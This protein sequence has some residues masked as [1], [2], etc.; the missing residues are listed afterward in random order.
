MNTSN[1]SKH[2]A[3]KLRDEALE[4]LPL[5]EFLTYELLKLTNLLNRQ[6]S[7]ILKSE[8]GLRLPEWRCM[9]FIGTYENIALYRIH[10]L[11]EIDQGLITRT[12]QALVEKKL[13]EVKK[14]LEDKRVIQAC[15]TKEGK[16]VYARV[17]PVMQARQVKLLR[18]LN[19]SER[20][21]IFQI[22]SKLRAAVD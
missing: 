15:L 5:E 14:D 22:L 2:S 1:K 12:I 3:A 4:D 13:V 16:K 7:A 18:A 21:A 11:T 9:A 20:S 17:R 19:V 10:E 6:A 8:A